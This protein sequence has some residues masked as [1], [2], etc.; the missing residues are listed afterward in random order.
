MEMTNRTDI[1][2]AA[3]RIYAGCL[4]SGRVNSNNEEETVRYCLHV[5]VTMAQAVEKRSIYNE[6][7]DVPFPL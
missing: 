7:G 2:E 6:G 5:A 4:A 1:L 3:S